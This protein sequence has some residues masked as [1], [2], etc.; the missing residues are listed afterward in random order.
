MCLKPLLLLV[1]SSQYT[2][3]SVADQADIKTS[4]NHLCI[5]TFHKTIPVVGVLIL[6]ECKR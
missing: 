2:G 4:T 5:H 3:T 6:D 1:Y